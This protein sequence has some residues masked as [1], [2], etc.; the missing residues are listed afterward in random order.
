[1]SQCVPV[2]HNYEACP[3]SSHPPDIRCVTTCPPPSV[4]RPQSPLSSRATSLSLDMTHSLLSGLLAALLLCSVSCSPLTS[5]TDSLNSREELLDSSDYQYEEYDNDRVRDNRLIVDME[6]VEQNKPQIKSSQLNLKRENLMNKTRRRR[7]AGGETGEEGSR[8]SEPL[9][10][11]DPKGWGLAHVLGEALLSQISV[12][13][14]RLILNVAGIAS[15]VC[16]VIY[17][18][19]ITYKLIKMHMGTYVREDPVFLKYK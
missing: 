9:L 19:G 6:E 17:I 7:Q 16:L 8:E 1:M 14:S 18:I 10:V 4:L 2:C 12:R 3:V 15:L 11:E 13:T 5:E